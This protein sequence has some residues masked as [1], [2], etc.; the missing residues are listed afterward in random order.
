MELKMY[1]AGNLIDS[2]PISEVQLIMPG[3]IGTL[4]YK[5]E[6]KHGDIIDSYE[7]EPEFYLDS[8]PSSMNL[9]KL[10]GLRT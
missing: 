8:I 3:F 10:R 6:E 9:Y 4:K 2:A 7:S 1:L 5:L